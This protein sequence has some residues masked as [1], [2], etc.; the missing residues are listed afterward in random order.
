[1]RNDGVDTDIEIHLAELLCS[2]L[3]HDL[4]SPVG[5]IHNGLELLA[6]DASEMEAEVLGL[7]HRS[8]DEASRRLRFFR[9][10]FGQGGGAA[11][12]LPLGEGRALLE[13]YLGGGRI[14]LGWREEVDPLASLANGSVKLL[15]NMALLASEAL[16]QG[17][18]LIV[19]V[20]CQTDKTILEVAAKG[21]SVFF[22]NE[23]VEALRLSLPVEKLNPRNVPA[24]FLARLLGKFGF[25]LTS[26]LHTDA[27]T[28]KVAHQR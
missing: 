18:D 1:M 7:L 17:G 21:K 16:P 19:A 8:S 27:I 20:A 28:L 5:A 25:T 26:N 6:Q 4:V 2:R 3:C 13:G 23:T 12:T 15:L 9:A 24:Y 22:K 14:H 10:A 11:E